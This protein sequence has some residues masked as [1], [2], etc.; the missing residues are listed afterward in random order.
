MH[1]NTKGGRP[2]KEHGEL[3]SKS[4]TVRLTEREHNY[5]NRQAERSDFSMSEYCRRA[6]MEQ[7]VKE[8][9]SPEVMLLLR[10]L[11]GIANNLNQAVHLAHV[12]GNSYQTTALQTKL[13]EVISLINRVRLS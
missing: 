10:S 8:R 6:A 11:F 7:Q 12:Y 3:L 5:L 4:I 9:I 2:P 13:D 1:N